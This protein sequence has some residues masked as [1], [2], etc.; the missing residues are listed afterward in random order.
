MTGVTRKGSKRKAGT[1]LLVGHRFKWRCWICGKKV[2]PHDH[3]GP[4]HASVDHV[5]SIR[6][7]GNNHFPNL[8]LAHQSC[9]AWR[10]GQNVEP[11]ATPR[12]GIKRYEESA[13]A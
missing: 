10:D 3:D 11:F 12:D 7:G 9:N 2:N 13:N 5:V 6:D 4:H 8:R 1:V